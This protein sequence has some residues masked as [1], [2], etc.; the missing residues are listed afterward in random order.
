MVSAKKQLRPVA[1]EVTGRKTSRF[2]GAF[3]K[4]GAI[5]SYANRPCGWEVQMMKMLIDEQMSE[6]RR[7]PPGEAVGQALSELLEKDCYLLN[8][9]ANE[10]S[11]TFRFAMHLQKHLPEWT[12]DCEYNRDGIDPKRLEHLGLYPPS[13]DEDAQTVFP[14]V[15]VHR[16]GTGQNYLVVEF[17]KSTSRVNRQIDL[18][19][20]L[21][22]RQQ[23]GY[24]HALFIEVGTDGQA[25]IEKLKWVEATMPERDL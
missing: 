15:I 18:R 9:D 14:D 19:K 1:P 22:Y 20:L 2:S 11:I 17:K 23:L 21:G 12:V 24:V 25:T 6:L 10:R 7:Y 8:I 3:K 4:P 13:D 5:S 16:R